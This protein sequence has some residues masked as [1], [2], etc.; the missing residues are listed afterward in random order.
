MFEESAAAM[1]MTNP[2]ASPAD[3]GMATPEARRGGRR[4]GREG[5]PGPRPLTDDELAPIINFI[6]AVAPTAY[7]ESGYGGRGLS[8]PVFDPSSEGDVTVTTT[9][10]IAYA[11]EGNASG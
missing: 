9:R 7:Y 2:D 4:G 3:G 6:L 10:T 1:P 8:V 11:I 5:R